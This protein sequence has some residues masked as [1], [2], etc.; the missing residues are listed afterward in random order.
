MM[1]A[2][3]DTLTPSPSTPVCEAPGGPD[4]PSRDA[5]RHPAEQSAE[6]GEVGRW[7]PAL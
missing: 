5:T 3:E 6:L 1:E 2:G 4:R 7:F